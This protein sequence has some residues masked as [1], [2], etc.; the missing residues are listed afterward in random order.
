MFQ[1][2]CQ[3]D[4]LVQ[5][6]KIL[7]TPSKQQILEM[8]P[9]YK[10]FKF[11]MVK[12]YPW[13]KIF[14]G[15]CIDDDYIDLIGKL[16]SYEPNVRPTPLKA[17]LHPFFDELRIEGVKLPSGEEVPKDLFSFTKEEYNSDPASVE[18]CIPSWIK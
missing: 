2:R 5:I 17:L 7:G 12:Q 4:Q 13:A 10:E 16:L 18:K 14:K 11:P 8:N 1:H 3:T 9:Q 15:K 6:I